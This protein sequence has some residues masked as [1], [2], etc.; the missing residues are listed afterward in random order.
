MGT[1]IKDKVFTNV[2]DFISWLDENFGDFIEKHINDNHVHHTWIPDHDTN[3]N[4]STLQLHKNM[5]NYHMNTNGWNDIA[6]NV[7]IGADGVIVTGRTIEVVPVSAKYYNGTVNWHPFAYEMIGNFDEGNDVLA[8]E[9]L[10]AAIKISQYFYNK[11]KGVVF[12]RECLINGKQPKS[13]PGT[14]IA[15]D[16]FMDLVKDVNFAADKAT[17]SPT[18]K[19]DKGTTNEPSRNYLKKDDTGSRVKTLQERLI[20][21]GYELPK[22][23]ADSEFGDETD[24]ALREMQEDA[25]ITVDGLYGQESAKALDDI[26]E[27]QEGKGDMDTNSIVTYLN[28]IGANSSYSN[29]AKLAAKY[30]IRGYEGTAA[31]NT[32]LLGIMR[33]KSK[34]AAPVV[35]VKKGDMNTGSIVT[36]LNSINVDSSYKNREKIAAK[37][38]IKGYKGTANQNTRLLDKLR[39]GPKVSTPSKAKGNQSTDSIVEYLNSINVNSSYKNREK[40]AAKYGIRDYKGEADQNLLLLKKIRG[41]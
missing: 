41:H 38:G 37:Y 9:Q 24:S 32:K 39:E 18:E 3:E 30:G 10:E 29:R 4:N 1:W 14:G 2:D 23:G 20:K 13:C 7:T 19:V 11:G 25:G 33:N 28:S 35:T 5:R 22:Y 36:Y 27:A 16:W 31:Q 34:P 12:H 15:K 26:L 6:Q 17:S 40:I 8:G 21:A